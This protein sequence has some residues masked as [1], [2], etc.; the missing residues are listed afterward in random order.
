[1]YTSMILM[2]ELLIILTEN[3]YTIT[4]MNVV[5]L[6]SWLAEMLDLKKKKRLEHWKHENYVI[7][8]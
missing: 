8:K 5:K 6:F 1:M 3:I 2:Y 4:I 7:G